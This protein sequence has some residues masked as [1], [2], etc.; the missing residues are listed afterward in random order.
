MNPLAPA[1]HRPRRGPAR[2]VREHWPLLIPLVPAILLRIL[3]MLAYPPV[4]WLMS[5]SISYLDDGVHLAPYAWR[6]SGYSILLYLLHPL[7]SLAAAAAVQHLFGLAVGVA[8]YALCR[9]FGV[10]RWAAALATVPQLYDG[11]VL[12]VEQSLLSETQFTILLVAMF[13]LL[14]W[15]YGRPRTWAVLLAGL[16]LSAADLT[17]SA[18]LALVVV[19]AVFLLVWR[20]RM[21]LVAGFVV[22]FAVPVLLYSAAYDHDYHEFS[23]G[24]TGLQLYGDV[25]LFADCSH[26][27]HVDHEQQLC[28]AQ[29]PGTYVGKRS[30][31][32]FDSDSPV[33]KLPGAFGEIDRAASAFDLMVIKHQPLDYLHLTVDH[34]ARYFSTS[35]D[36]VDYYQ[37]L[38]QYPALPA[39]AV[40]TGQAYVG[41][42]TNVS[43]RPSPTLA[44]VMTDY[45][46]FGF[47]PGPLY[48][49][50]LL[51]GLA[52]W[53]F[54]R[55]PDGRRLRSM[56]A[57]LSLSALAMFVTASLIVANSERYRLTTLP[58]L[59][60]AAALGATLLVRRFRARRR[61][62]AAA[63]PVEQPARSPA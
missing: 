45:Q 60:V 6:P 19:V 38:R 35:I 34:L 61:A 11:Y 10:P 48:L 63:E 25:M 20:V 54:G 59:S 51:I 3:V 16:L 44:P 4:L 49:A 58:L 21:R 50:L 40:Q 30:W 23:T 57:L 7:H 17:R 46:K 42:A 22:V 15:R 12:S 9:R 2:L 32:I 37:F 31:Y 56:C 24:A 53:L 13:L 26:L 43:T 1:P 5:D 14:A 29:P 39:L 47:A 27:P 55:D 33:W 52:G 62:P 8:I 28:V 41:S 18:G 36:S